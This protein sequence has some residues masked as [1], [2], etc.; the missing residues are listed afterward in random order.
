VAGPLAP[1]PPLCSGLTR[2]LMR[3]QLD[4]HQSYTARTQPSGDATFFSSSLHRDSIH[5]I[6][7]R[8]DR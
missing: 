2:N 3:G 7:K 5:Q 1:L 8:E 4:K 6:E